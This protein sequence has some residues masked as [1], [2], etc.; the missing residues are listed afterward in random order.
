MKRMFACFLCALAF[1]ATAAA[2]VLDQ[3]LQ[4]AQIALASDGARVSLRLIP[5]VQVADRVFTLIDADGDGKI[6]PREEQAYVRRVLED[7]A[8]E[9]D[10]RPAPFAVRAVQFPTR[11]EMNEGTGAIR[12]E[13]AAEAAL[14]TPGNHQLSFRNDHLPEFAV[15]LANAL[16]PTTETISITGQQRDKLQHGLQVDFRV[17]SAEA[18]V[19]PRRTGVLLLG[20]CLALLL[21]QWKRLRSFLRR[22]EDEQ[23]HAKKTFS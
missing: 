3:Y 14:G 23:I 20:T 8:L 11:P 10:G 9:V 7:I 2:H 16:I 19:W 15:Y 13:L 17:V 21:P 5:G 18:S 4:S 6:S 1:Q 12:L 22:V